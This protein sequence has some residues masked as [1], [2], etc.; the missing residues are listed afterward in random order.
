MDK[1]YIRNG[2]GNRHLG[3][4]ARLEGAGVEK[5]AVLYD[6]DKKI[7]EVITATNSVSLGDN[8]GLA[9]MDSEY[10]YPSLELST[11]PGGEV[12]ART[13]TRP[14]TVSE[15]LIKGMQQ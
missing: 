9:L 2:Y 8:I 3:R 14:M 12:N 10:A 15:S 13:V 7:G 1:F 6:G 11:V 5:G 4:A